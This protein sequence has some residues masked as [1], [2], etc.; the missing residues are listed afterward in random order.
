MGLGGGGGTYI[1]QVNKYTTRTFETGTLLGLFEIV[2][3]YVYCDDHI[4]DMPASSGPIG[5]GLG[6]QK[7]F[8][9]QSDQ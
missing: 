2:K 8:G 3:K 4:S 1:S 6:W 9:H 5:Y 7:F